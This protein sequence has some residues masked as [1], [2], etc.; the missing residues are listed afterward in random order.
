LFLISH[1]GVFGLIFAECYNTKNR[2]I[3]TLLKAYQLR[4]QRSNKSYQALCSY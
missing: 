2:L 1:I 3:P 4:L